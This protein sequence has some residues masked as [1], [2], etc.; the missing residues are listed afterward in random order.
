[1]SKPAKKCSIHGV[2]IIWEDGGDDKPTI[3]GRW[4][5]PKCQQRLME[6]LDKIE[7]KRQ[8]SK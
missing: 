5:C 7:Q 1:M 2:P 8:I 4:Y 3:H 6:A